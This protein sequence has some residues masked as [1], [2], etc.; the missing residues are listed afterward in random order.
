MSEKKTVEV[1]E[2]IR[3]GNP[4]LRKRAREVTSAELSSTEIQ[5][6]IDLMI[7]TMHHAEGIGL[8]APQVGVPLR[9]ALVQVPEDS[10]R[11]PDAPAQELGIY[12][13]PK[14]TLLDETTQGF[15]EGCLSVPGLRGFVDRP[16]K[17]RIDYLDRHGKE[18]SREA[19]GFLA[20]VFQHEF[21]H[22]DGILF[23]D[24]VTD[25]SKIAYLEEY[26]EFHA[27]K[28][29]MPEAPVEAKEAPSI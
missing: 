20:T 18:H 24:R 4:V 5:R 17:I 1:L 28:E 15:W 7:P 29:E 23:L 11:Y 19:E 10:E 12:I 26:A 27:P 2:I 14:V 21:D 16:S 3:M 9:I 22:L 13:N 8:A 6:L 25:K